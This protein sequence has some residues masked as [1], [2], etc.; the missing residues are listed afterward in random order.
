MHGTAETDPE[1]RDFQRLYGPW[2]PWDVDEATAQLDGI[3]APWWICGGQAI[4]AFTGRRRPHDDVDI[5]MFWEDLPRL[6]TH[7][8]GRFHLW[9]VGSGMLRPLD[10]TFPELH[11]ESE[12]VWLRQHALAPW[13]ADFVITRTDSSEWVFKFDPAVRMPLAHATWLDERSRRILRP[14]VVLAHKAKLS[15]PKDDAD[16]ATTWPLLGEPARRWLNEVVSRLFPSHPWLN[17]MAAP[18]RPVRREGR[19]VLL[20]EA[21]LD[22]A[23]HL[24]AWARDRDTMM[25]EF[26]DFGLPPGKPL[27][28]KL[29]RG[30]RMVSREAGQLV[31]ERLEDGAVLGDV[32]WHQQGY[33]PTAESRVPNIGISLVPEARGRG[34][35]VESQ[36]L[37]AELLFELYDVV[38]VE[39]S[40]DVE[41]VAEQR[42][43][44]K[45]GFTREGVL[46]QAQHR[47]GAHHDM[48][49]YSVLRSELA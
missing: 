48:L 32:S 39:A 22:D 34:Y 37:L 49:V 41:N 45:A 36:R 20:R 47:A 12:Q 25:G 21:T 29:D 15:R 43:L 27:A 40:T 33:G 10:A 30:K 6:R 31:V 18:D 42:A 19:R 28:E 38:R 4:E 24:D 7:F 1:E 44:D 46:R 3:D 23:A 11:G 13:R 9:S 5:G 16:F 2:E 14:E 35:G 26:N 8:S 17:R